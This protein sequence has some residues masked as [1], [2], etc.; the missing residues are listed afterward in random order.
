MIVALLYVF[1]RRHFQSESLALL[2]AFIAAIE[3]FFVAYSHQARNYSMSF[4]L[5]LLAT[6]LFLLIIEH[7]RRASPDASSTPSKLYLIYGLVFVTSLLSHYLTITVFLCHGLY[8]LFFLR[9]VKRWVP[10]AMTAVVGVALVSL[11]F[12][13]GGGKYTFQTLAY[14]GKLYGELA[15][16]HPYDN[17][18]AI[19][20]PATLPNLATKSAPLWADLL[21]VSNGLGQ[22]ETLGIRNM[23]MAFFFGLIALVVLIRYLRSTDRPI[24]L[25]VVFGLLLVVGMPFYTVPKL[26]YIVLSAFPSF[27]FL[28]FLY[29]KTRTSSSQ[30]PLLWFMAILAVVPTL[31][32]VVMSIKNNHTYGLTQ[33]YSGFSFPYSII[34][35]AM[36]LQQVWATPGLLKGVLGVVLGIQGYLVGSLLVRIYQDRDPKYTYFVEP[37]TENPYWLTANKIKANYA[38]GDTVL[39]P[40]VKLN[41]RD[42]IEMTYD[43]YS[44]MD[45]QLTNL[46]LPKDAT[47][48][49]RMDTTQTD[50][51]I[52]IKGGT[53]E[54]KILFDFE[55]RKYRF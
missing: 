53:G 12:I 20:L 6:H 26:Q 5:T 8:A 15:Q 3:P 14:Q 46:Y 55:G 45:A 22:V 21:M 27:L 24:W 16:T 10:F 1:V 42:T 36:I 40:S 30:N 2:S 34:F 33:R 37:R 48:Y 54:R 51:V 17:P 41:P 4:F 25:V 32:L 23:A 31:F 47:Y 13:F 35:V 52:L 43:P 29:L 7:Y 28:L 39:Y 44:I 49:Q 50:Q 18:F 19:I 11:W 9:P 38:P